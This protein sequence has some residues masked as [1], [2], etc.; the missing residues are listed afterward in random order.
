MKNLRNITNRQ[1][2]Y[3]IEAGRFSYLILSESYNDLTAALLTTE[4]E[5]VDCRKAVTA[6]RNAWQF[7]DNAFRF[8]T[9]ISQIKGFRHKDERFKIVEKTAVQI[10]RARNFI[11]HLNSGIPGLSDEIYPILGAISWP[12]RDGKS[13]YTISL[14]ALPDGTHFN[15]L[16]YNKEEKAY[17]P[18]ILL[19]VDTFSV[20]LSESFR[21]MTS[22]SEYLN[23]WLSAQEMIAEQDITPN[24]MVAGP[25]DNVPSNMKFVRAKIKVNNQNSTEQTK[26][27]QINSREGSSA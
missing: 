25:L 17:K 18:D 22:G 9:V 1:I 4:T 3:R 16:G 27:P 8:S 12:S 14:G 11:Q 7:I 26:S 20:N 19:D 5:G 24:F 21:A 2:V 15:S 23:E 13:S 10:E 6:F